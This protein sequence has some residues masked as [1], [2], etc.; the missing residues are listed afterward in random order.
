MRTPI[1][2]ELVGMGASPNT[3]GCRDY[4]IG[5]IDKVL[6]HTVTISIEERQSCS[7]CWQVGHDN[8]HEFM[9]DDTYMV[10][11]PEMRTAGN[12]W[13]TAVTWKW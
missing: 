8:D 1:V 2:G 13:S 3:H 6:L 7:S 4:A 11:I 10:P 9:A 5:R 12:N